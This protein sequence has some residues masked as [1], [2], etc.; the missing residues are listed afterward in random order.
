MYSI[1][2]KFD[3]LDTQNYGTE[4]LEKVAEAG[5]ADYVIQGSFSK[6]GDKFRVDYALQDILTGEVLGSESVEGEG[7]AGIYAM[8]DELTRKIKS[9]LNISAANIAD[10]MDEDINWISTSSLEA[11]KHW[12]RALTYASETNW[13]LSVQS[14]QKAVA[15]DP[16][17]ALA[18][19]LMATDYNNMGKHAERDA[20]STKAM[21]L[22]D[23]TS[24]RERYKIEG[25]YYHR[26]EKNLEKTIEAYTKVLDVYPKDGF[27]NH[28][29]GQVYRE[30]EQWDKA[31]KFYRV[32]VDE[33]EDWLGYHVLLAITLDAKGLHVKAQEVLENYLNEYSDH[34]FVRYTLAYS[35]F[36]GPQSASPESKRSRPGPDFGRY[37]CL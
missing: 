7:E 23:K 36:R 25:Y 33:G 30:L 17:F 1:L 26:V 31:I 3:L 10:D 27:G 35:S 21:E 5:G 2:R 34:Y 16:E 12:S 20:A 29:L 14:L 18:Y 22:R 19:N 24:Y 6:A 32:M 4:E 11:L 9:E 28:M 37:L 8:V 13:E 15:A